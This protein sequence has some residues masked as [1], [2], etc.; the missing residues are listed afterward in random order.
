MGESGGGG[1]AAANGCITGSMWA[2][3]G[4][5]G[6]GIAGQ[7]LSLFFAVV[8]GMLCK[9]DILPSALKTPPPSTPKSSP[10]PPACSP[11]QMMTKP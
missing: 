1:A 3:Q 4:M 2:G 9:S 7:G 5:L 6:R 8:G 11:I 10:P